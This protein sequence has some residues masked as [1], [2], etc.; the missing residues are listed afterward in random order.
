VV[1]DFP[2]GFAQTHLKDG[3]SILG[4]TFSHMIGASHAGRG[5]D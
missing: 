5:Y 3:G 1:A 2:R 4:M